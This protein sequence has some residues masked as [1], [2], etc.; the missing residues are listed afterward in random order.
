MHRSLPFRIF[1][2]IL[3]ANLAAL[4]DDINQVI[5]AGAD[6][7]HFDVM[8]NHY[9]PN[10]TFGAM[11][12]ESLKQFGIQKAF[13]VHLMVEPV[14]KLIHDFAKAGADM[15]SIHPEATKHLH[16]SLRNIKNY[17]C[18]AGIAINPATSLEC[19]PPVIPYIDFILVMSV[20]PGFGGQQFIAESINKIKQID[21]LLQQH[22]TQHISIAVDGGITENNIKEVA[23]AGADTFI[24]GSGIFKTPNYQSTIQ[25][26][27]K[28]LEEVR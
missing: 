1:P 5:K 21:Q 17:N 20:N 3:A 6:A 18:E 12:L 15:I 27:R 23:Q 22:N 26:M 24:V 13:D 25:T 7:I 19:I 11:L 8:D 14:D 16:A 9:V 4:G 2:S 10:L 28:K